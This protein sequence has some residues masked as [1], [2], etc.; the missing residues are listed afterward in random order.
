M[1]KLTKGA[2]AETTPPTWTFQIFTGPDGFD[3]GT[4]LA[5]DTTPPSTLDF[6]NLNLD[7]TKQYTLCETNVAA[8][9]TSGWWVDLD[10]NAPTR[11]N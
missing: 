2:L 4:S 9:W 3:T 5:T 10:S 7:P 8:G 11:L 1:H 6:G